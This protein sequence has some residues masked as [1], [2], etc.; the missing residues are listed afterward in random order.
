MKGTHLISEPDERDTGNLNLPSRRINS[1]ENGHNQCRVVHPEAPIQT[2]DLS[3]GGDSQKD[4]R[5]NRRQVPKLVSSVLVRERSRDELHPR[6]G[7]HK[8]HPR[9]T[10]SATR[11]ADAQRPSD[12]RVIVRRGPRFQLQLHP[13]QPGLD[14]E[15]NPGHQ[16][17]VFRKPPPGADARKRLRGQVSP[18]G[19]HRV[20]LVREDVRRHEGYRHQEEESEPSP[21]TPQVRQPFRIGFFGQPAVYGPKGH[22]P[23]YPECY[24]YRPLSRR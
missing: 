4:K 9:Q 24:D 5:E 20:Q 21:S 16:A 10:S 12:L 13:E 11:P 2:D 19:E 22:Y 15:S 23:N 1:V 6:F 7:E 3:H 17:R 18:R 8:T 14:A